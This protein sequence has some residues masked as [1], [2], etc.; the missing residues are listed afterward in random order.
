MMGIQNE[1]ASYERKKQRAK[2][3]R[4]KLNE[5]IERLSVAI[6]LAGNQSKQRA[7]AHAYW[8]NKE[9]SYDNNNN[10]NNNSSSSSSSSLSSSALSTSNNNTK[11]PISPSVQTGIKGTVTIME[12]AGKT[13]DQ[14]KKWERPSFVGSAATII[15]NLNAQC[16]ALMRELIDLKKLQND[17]AMQSCQSCRKDRNAG[18]GVVSDFSHDEIDHGSSNDV[19]MRKSKKPKLCH[20]EYKVNINAII[21]R[22]KMIGIIGSFLDPQ[23]ILQFMCVLKSWKVQLDP[24]MKS[25]LIWSPLC[26]K[27][28]GAYSVREWLN[29]DDENNF[30]LKGD[31]ANSIRTSHMDLYRQMNVANVKPKCHYEGNINLGGGKINN[32]ACAWITAVERSNGET[33]RSVLTST[34]GEIKYASVPVVELRIL[35]QNVGIADTAILIPEQ[36]I[37]IDASTKRRGEEMFEITS[38]ER[39]SKKVYRVD[40]SIVSSTPTPNRMN[41]TIGNLF[42][43]NL[44]ESAILSIFIHAKSCAT[45]TKFRQRANFA[46]IL[47]NVRGTTIPLVIPISD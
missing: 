17:G 33:L 5:S 8:A 28:F 42:K 39:M 44:F 14:A 9:S 13:A 35:I 45:T 32:V 6:N 15:Q 21:K 20:E 23:S 47:L 46:K 41:H 26:V 22:D 3:A 43:L 29:K 24:T 11:G 40:G 12:E 7:Q 10:N 36:I 19:P 16:E 27:R 30:F 25:D 37:S 2:D 31:D 4:V 38:D 34:D 1:G 18:V